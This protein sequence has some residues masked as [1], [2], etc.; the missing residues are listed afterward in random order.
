MKWHCLR[1]IFALMLSA[2]MAQ[3]QAPDCPSVVGDGGVYVTFADRFVHYEL[4]DDGLISERETYFDDDTIYAYRSHPIGVWFESW[5]IY[6]DRV[7][8]DSHETVSLTGTPATLPDPASGVVWNG[9]ETS[10]YKDGFSTTYT[11]QIVVDQPTT[12]TIGACRYSM[13]PI[14]VNR[15]DVDEREVIVD[16]LG[17][18]DTLGITIYLGYGADVGGPI[19]YDMPTTIGVRPPNQFVAP[20]PNS[21]ENPK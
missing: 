1:M 13:L 11:T 2:N 10:T 8:D 7:I 4:L 20:T 12:I 9:V 19:D 16:A 5:E 14:T 21:L 15:V 6:D 17:Y 18:L 3:A